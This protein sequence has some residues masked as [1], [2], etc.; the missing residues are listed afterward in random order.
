M[1][2]DRQAASEE[3]KRNTQS[4]QQPSINSIRSFS[5][6]SPLFDM[7]NDKSSSATMKLLLNKWINWKAI[8]LV[9][10][11]NFSLNNEEKKQRPIHLEIMQNDRKHFHQ[12]IGSALRL[13]CHPRPPAFV[14]LPELNKLRL[15]CTSFSPRNRRINLFRCI[16]RGEKHQQPKNAEIDH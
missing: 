12:N 10:L 16:F 13:H 3:V 7:S 14:L 9:A 2:R 5:P 8:K 11:L 6:S 1:R 15:H 4:I